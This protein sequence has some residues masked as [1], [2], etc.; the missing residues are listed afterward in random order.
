MD[1]GLS[2]MGAGD[3]GVR[4]VSVSEAGIKAQQIRDPDG[5]ARRSHSMR[6]FQSEFQYFYLYI[7]GTCFRSVDALHQEL[8]F[9]LGLPQWYGRNWDALLDCLSS[10]GD[11]LDNLCATWDWI[12]VKRLVLAVQSFSKDN[13]DTDTLLTFL[14]VIADA[15]DRLTKTQSLNRIWFEYNAPPIN[16][17]KQHLV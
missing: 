4:V 6:R 11:P 15:N 2:P 17:A 10:I 12:D 14:Q 16:T 13:V 5:L 8:S 1:E 9:K 3:D 7:D